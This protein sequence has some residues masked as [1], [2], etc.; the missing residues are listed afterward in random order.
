[1]EIFGNFV[2]GVLYI[3]IAAIILGGIVMLLWNWLI[4]VIFG[5]GTINFV[6]GWG[7]AVLS[8]ILFKNSS[9][10]QFKGNREV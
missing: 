9:V 6:Q 2:L 8:G 5:L 7:L 4:P 1:M 3:L 10:V